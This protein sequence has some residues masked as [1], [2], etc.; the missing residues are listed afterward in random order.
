MQRRGGG[1][2]SPL[3]VIA[4]LA[5]TGKKFHLFVFFTPVCFGLIYRPYIIVG[6]CC[7]V[8]YH[9]TALLYGLHEDDETTERKQRFTHVYTPYTIHSFLGHKGTAATSDILASPACLESVYEGERD[10][11]KEREREGERGREGERER[12]RDQ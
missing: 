8:G 9:E 1:N 4:A 2:R 6:P 3:L 5:E 11:Q 7:V 10:S 12:G